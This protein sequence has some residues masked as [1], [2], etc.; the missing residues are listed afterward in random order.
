MYHNK[1][2]ILSTFYLTHSFQLLDTSSILLKLDYYNFIYH[3]RPLYTNIPLK[4]LLYLCA[5]L[6]LQISKYSRLHITPYLKSLHWL[7]ISQRI[8]YKIIFMTHLAKHH[9]SPDYISHLLS[10]NTSSRHQRTINT[11]KL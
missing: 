7:P 8:K 10:D 9:N 6:I 5:R 4:K 1:I 11:F 2:I 3:Y